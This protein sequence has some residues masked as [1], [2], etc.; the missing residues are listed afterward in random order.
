MWLAD[1]WKDYE[2]IDSCRRRKA[3]TLGAVHPGTSGSAGDLGYTSHRQTLETSERHTIT[4]VKKAAV[5][6]NSSISRNSGKFS[7]KRSDL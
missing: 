4:A 5:N 6:G 1:G 3:G 2:V 7:Y